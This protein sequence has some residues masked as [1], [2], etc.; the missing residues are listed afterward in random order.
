M[1]TINLI[2]TKTFL[3]YFSVSNIITFDIL[4]KMYKHEMIF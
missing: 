3:M 2:K 1:C 4:Q